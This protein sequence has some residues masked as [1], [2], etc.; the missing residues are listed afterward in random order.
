MAQIMVPL[1]QA[2]KYSL[3]ENLCERVVGCRE[4][5]LSEGGGKA[6]CLCDV[7]ATEYAVAHEAVS[8]PMR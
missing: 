1:Q 2:R 5:S 4:Q 8:W 6:A 3:L 7:E